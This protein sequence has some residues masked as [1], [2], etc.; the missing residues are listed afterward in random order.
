MKGLDVVPHRRL[1]PALIGFSCIL[2]VVLPLAPPPP[3]GIT[4]GNLTHAVFLGAVV[5][6]G[7]VSLAC[8]W[9]KRHQREGLVYIG[10]RQELL[11]LIFLAAIGGVGMHA[12]WQMP[13]N[14]CLVLG[15][16]HRLDCNIAFWV[17]W[18]TLDIVFLGWLYLWGL[19]FERLS[20][21]TLVYRFAWLANDP[22]IAKALREREERSDV[23]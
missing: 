2:T 19:R 5:G 17:M 14:I 21:R 9:I 16:T 1:V 10:W 15:A 12:Y 3:Q 22:E 7:L 11:F 6:A 18:S 20:G 13:Y 4:I 23:E 8:R